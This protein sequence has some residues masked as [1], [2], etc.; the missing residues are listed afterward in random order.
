MVRGGA[1]FLMHRELLGLTTGDSRQGDHINRDRLDNRRANLRIVT[2]AENRQNLAAQRGSTSAYRGVSWD[3]QAEKWR[4]SAKLDGK[5]KFLGTFEREEDAGRAAADF[6]A[7]HMPCSAEGAEATAARAL[8]TFCRMY[9]PDERVEAFR[10]LP[11]VHRR[12]LISALG[13]GRL[14]ELEAARIAEALS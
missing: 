7:E 2:L 3:K 5:A 1:G 13:R 11:E 8:K 10:L 12:R 4:A 9:Q 14:S 6:R